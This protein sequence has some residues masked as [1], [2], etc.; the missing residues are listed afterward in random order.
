MLQHSD[1]THHHM[2]Y[3]QLLLP[4]CTAFSCAERLYL[5]FASLWDCFQQSCLLGNNA[6]QQLQTLR[7]LV[8]LILQRP[9]MLHV[10]EG[11]PGTG[12]LGQEGGE[13]QRM[14]HLACLLSSRPPACLHSIGMI[15]GSHFDCSQ[16]P[17]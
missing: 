16:C 15:F 8:N 2:L 11:F 14:G 9:V 6:M 1:H 13:G 4:M 12:L 3:L 17:W 5:A 10:V 7:L